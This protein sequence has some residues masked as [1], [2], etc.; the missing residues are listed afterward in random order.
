MTTQQYNILFV[1]AGLTEINTKENGEVSNVGKEMFP[2][3]EV[4]NMSAIEN[5]VRGDKLQLFIPGNIISL[6]RG[7]INNLFNYGHRMVVVDSPNL[8]QFDRGIWRN[9]KWIRV[10]VDK[11]VGRPYPTSREKYIPIS[12]EIEYTDLELYYHE[13]RQNK[14]TLY[15]Q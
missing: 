8:T 4:V 14:G 15:A 13:K 5:T 6:M 10:F 7:E 9:D 12:P 3:L 11:R 1:L 2:D